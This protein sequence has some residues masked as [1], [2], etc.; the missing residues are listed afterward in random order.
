MNKLRNL[1][2]LSRAMR[3]LG[4]LEARYLD[5]E[6]EY[7]ADLEECVRAIKALEFETGVSM[8]DVIG[9]LS[10]VNTS[11]TLSEVFFRGVETRIIY[12]LNEDVINP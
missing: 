1:V 6:A 2:N 8:S 5:A 12:A 4:R 9:F 7:N 11:F 3:T 10:K